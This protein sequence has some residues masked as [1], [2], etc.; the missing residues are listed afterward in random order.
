M[1]L[2]FLCFIFFISTIILSFLLYRSITSITGYEDVYSDIYNMLIPLN[3]VI[4]SVLNRKIY[5]NERDVVEMVDRLSDLQDYISSFVQQRNQ[6][7]GAI[8]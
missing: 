8:E 6:D 4:S 2:E 1:I 7:L 3:T 5:S